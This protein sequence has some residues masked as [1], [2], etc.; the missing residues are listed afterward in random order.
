MET[1]RRG[2]AIL[3]L[4]LLAP[5][6]VLGIASALIWW[7]GPVGQTI[8]GVAKIWL[9]LMPITWYMVFDKGRLSWSP[10]RH[11]GLGLGL[12]V[13]LIMGASVGAGYF[14]LALGQIDPAALRSEVAEMGIASPQLYILGAA[15]WIFVNSVAEEYVFRWFVLGKCE[16]LFGSSVAI[17]ISAAVFTIHHVVAVATYLDPVFTALASAGVFIA[18]ITWAWM[19]TRYRSIWPGWVAH[20]LADLAVFAC[21]WHLLFE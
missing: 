7:P 16:E 11:G 20:A 10:V 13:G 8:F 17:V 21:G 5:A 18:G 15:Y 19:Y 2:P 1:D 4:F 14:M 6:P 3:A 9:L 12:L